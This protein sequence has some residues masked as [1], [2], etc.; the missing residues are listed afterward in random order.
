VRFGFLFKTGDPRE[1]ADPAAAAEAAGWDWVFTWDGV[2]IGTYDGGTFGPQRMWIA[3]GPP[4][5]D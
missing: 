5:V 4:R 3:I 1:A 2:A